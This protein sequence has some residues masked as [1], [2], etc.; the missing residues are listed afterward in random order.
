MIK[1]LDIAKITSNYEPDLSQA[2]QRVIKKGWFMQGD[3]VSSFEQEYHS[4]IGTK[5]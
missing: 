4:F 3:E 2:I 1:F 5:Y